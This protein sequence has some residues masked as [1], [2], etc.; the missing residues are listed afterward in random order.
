MTACERRAFLCCLG[1]VK[2]IFGAGLMLL[3]GVGSGARWF[4]PVE[5][6]TIFGIGAAVAVGGHTV[7]QWACRPQKPKANGENE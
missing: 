1:V 7:C 4:D 6:R 3:A 2:L 5:V